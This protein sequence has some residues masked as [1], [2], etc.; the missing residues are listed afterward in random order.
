MDDL[1]TSL[2]ERERNPQADFNQHLA[3]LGRAI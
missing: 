1:I 2:A 3:K